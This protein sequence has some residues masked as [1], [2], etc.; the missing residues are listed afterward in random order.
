MV[1]TP[2]ARLHVLV[3][4]RLA[5]VLA[6]LEQH[7]QRLDER[8]LSPVARLELIGGIL[9]HFI[10][11]QLLFL[12]RLLHSLAAHGI[13]RLRRETLEL[14]LVDRDVAPR[15]KP[16]PAA[17]EP[18]QL[19]LPDRNRPLQV[20]TISDDIVRRRVRHRDGILGEETL[21]LVLAQAFDRV[22][23]ARGEAEPDLVVHGP[24]A[25]QTHGA[26]EPVGAEQRT[27]SH[28]GR[29]TGRDRY[30]SLDHERGGEHRARRI[31][32]N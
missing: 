7:G 28:D 17:E 13:Q 16:G 22:H 2:V 30:V 11:D 31:A 29:V 10:I 27:F 15:L 23:V 3:L 8:R 14:L 19:A 4:G 18:P 20:G 24:A 6:T 25:Q 12:D 9:E 26:D 5:A 32:G 1:A 21:R